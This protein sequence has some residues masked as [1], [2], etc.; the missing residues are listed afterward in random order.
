VADVVVGA[1]VAVDSAAGSEGV[2]EA[3][4]VAAAEA[5]GSAVVAAVGEGAIL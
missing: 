5:A 1:A 2:E 4:S 3:A